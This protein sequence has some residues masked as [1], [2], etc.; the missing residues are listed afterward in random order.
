M[1]ARESLTAVTAPLAIRAELRGRLDAYKA[2]VARHGLAEDT[3]LAERYEKARRML[4]SAP[5][6][7]R[8][9]EEAV[10]RYQHA[11]AELLGTAQQRVPRQ[12]G[13]HGQ[14]GRGPYGRPGR[15]APEERGGPAHE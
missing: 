11:A 15:G 10:L 4:W 8:V 7:L 5:C 13:P 2:K 1:R 14:S 9:A 12:S 3:V 6:D